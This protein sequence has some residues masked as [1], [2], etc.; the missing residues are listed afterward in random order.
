MAV[1]FNLTFSFANFLTNV[2]D[3]LTSTLSSPATPS[4][5]YNALDVYAPNPAKVVDKTLFGAASGSY[6]GI[7]MYPVPQKTK[8]LVMSGN[9]STANGIL[10]GHNSTQTIS[11]VNWGIT[12]PKTFYISMNAGGA[13]RTFYY[14]YVDT[15]GNERTMGY[16]IPTPITNWYALPLQ[17]GYTEQM[18]GIN[19]VRV[20]GSLTS[21][22]AYFISHTQSTANTVVSGTFGR[23][24]NAVITIPNNAIGYVS[25]VT[26]YNGIA[27]NFNLWKYDN[28]SGARKNIYYYNTP[29]ASNH[30]PAGFEGALGGILQPGEA[31]LGG[32]ENANFMVMFANVVIKYLS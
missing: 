4:G 18:V 28:Q 1:M 6:S 17:T 29:F 16:T 15:N 5:S 26:I 13:Q 11:N 8:Q 23:T 20:S 30:A 3:N 19:N 9:T 12:Q 14:D 7:N 24:F 32:N 10:G 2:Y 25:N 31:V 27:S 21:A 22:D